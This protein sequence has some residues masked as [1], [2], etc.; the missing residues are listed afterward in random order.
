MWQVCCTDSINSCRALRSLTER[1]QQCQNVRPQIW[2]VRET[3]W[4]LILTNIASLY[5]ALL[6][7]HRHFSFRHAWD[8]FQRS[9]EKLRM[10]CPCVWLVGGR[11]CW[12][13][14]LLLL[15]KFSMFNTGGHNAFFWRLWFWCGHAPTTSIGTYIYLC[16]PM[17]IYTYRYIYT[18]V[19]IYTHLTNPFNPL[20]LLKENYCPF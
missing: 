20:T 18:Y 16:I 5:I 2:L 12:R 17:Y 10:T 1:G 13:S 14:I 7:T 11:Q 3:I 8:M 15:V 4:S 6:W 19:Y 9:A